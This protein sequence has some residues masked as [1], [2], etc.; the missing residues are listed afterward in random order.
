MMHHTWKVY[1]P[2]PTNVDFVLKNLELVATHVAQLAKAS[3]L[4][5]SYPSKVK[6]VNK[7]YNYD[8]FN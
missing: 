1:R 5:F 6:D 4:L 3:E 7:F 8:M 2:E